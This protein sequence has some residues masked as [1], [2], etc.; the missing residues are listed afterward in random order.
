MSITVRHPDFSFESTRPHWARDLEFSH[1]WNGTSIIP[2]H[3]EPYLIKVFESA[4][5]LVKDA[6]LQRDMDL[7][8]SQERLHC[9]F[10][11]KFNRVL[12]QHYPKIRD[13]EE[14]LRNELNDFLTNRSRRFHL[15]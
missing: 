13:C 12:R 3:V 15:A 9:L 11:M 7:F 4:R 1:M 8:M 14:R 6:A 5:P 2:A 10:H